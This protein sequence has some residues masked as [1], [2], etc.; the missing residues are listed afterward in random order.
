MFKA[1][2]KKSNI[3]VVPM[4]FGTL[5][6]E[7][8]L[9]CLMHIAVAAPAY[10]AATPWSKL[11]APEEIMSVGVHCQHDRGMPHLALRGDGSLTRPHGFE[12]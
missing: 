6:G 10:T 3:Y 4:A 8:V 11:E 1:D 2:E 9:A 5:I 7:M 12:I